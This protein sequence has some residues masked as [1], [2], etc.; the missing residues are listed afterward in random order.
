MLKGLTLLAATDIGSR[1][2]TK[3]AALTL[4]GAAGVVALIGVVFALLALMIWLSRMWSPLTASLAIAGAL[5][6]IA[7]V[8]V[9]AAR[10]QK[11]PATT[12][13]P[14]GSA[15]LFAAPAAL[16]IASRRLSFGTVAA[17]AAIAL[18][19]LVGRRIARDG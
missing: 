16:K 8:L 2:R 15:A 14:L 18:G 12:R 11:P 1:I 9:I 19:A 3:I 17:V 5:L 6:A 7:A 13:S 10:F 4:Y